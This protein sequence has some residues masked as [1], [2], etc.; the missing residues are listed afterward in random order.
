MEIFFSFLINGEIYLCSVEYILQN[1]RQR[2][3]KQNQGTQLEISV[4]SLM[5]SN[6][7]FHFLFSNAFKFFYLKNVTFSH[8]SAFTGWIKVTDYA[9]RVNGTFGVKKWPSFLQEWL[10]T[11]AE[12]KSPELLKSS[13]PVHNSLTRAVAFATF[14][15]RCIPSLLWFPVKNANCETTV[16]ITCSSLS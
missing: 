5:D 10:G 14:E 3:K 11:C 16:T 7:P 12:N 2:E 13:A 9:L 8:F 6:N 15:G 1:K 4:F